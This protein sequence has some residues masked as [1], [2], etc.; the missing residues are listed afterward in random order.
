MEKKTKTGGLNL[1][2]QK[3][4]VRVHRRRERRKGGVSN[5]KKQ[6][7]MCKRITVI[8]LTQNTRRKVGEGQEERKKNGFWVVKMMKGGWGSGEES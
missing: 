4:I 5:K 6:D 1:A 2:R 8:Y 3:K 7:A